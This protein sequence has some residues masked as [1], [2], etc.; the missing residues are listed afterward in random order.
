MTLNI[1]A[2]C[3][4]LT[5]ANSLDTAQG[6]A[7]AQ[8][9]TAQWVVVADSWRRLVH[10]CASLSRLV[11]RMAVALTCV[12]MERNVTAQAALA[13]AGPCEES[14]PAARTFDDVTEE[15]VA[16]G[17]RRMADAGDVAENTLRTYDSALRG[18]DAWLSERRPGQ[19][20]DDAALAEYLVVLKSRGRSAASAGQVVAAAK[21]RA[22]QQGEASPAGR[23]T[24]EM[25]RRYRRTPKA[26]R[27]Q[28]RGISWEEAD[29]M[30]DLAARSGG[31]RGLRD[32]ALVSMTSDA[33]LRV[34]EVASVRVEDVAFEDDGTARL[35]VRSGKTDQTGRG[36]VLFLGMP[37][38][39]RVREWM[40]VAGIR[41]GP[42]FRRLPR[43][44]AVS[45]FGI[46]AGSVRRVI[47]QRA[48]A[49]GIEGRV[50]GHSLRVGSAQSLAKRGAGLVEMQKAGR[51]ASPDMPA[52]YT[53]SQR[54]AEGAVAR[55]RYRHDAEAPKKGEKAKER[56]TARITRA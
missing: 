18:L 38:A 54:V 39:T 36:A 34:S 47:V 46:G 29:E 24:A 15:D 42:L 27:G 17:T 37:T 2:A 43:G 7:F 1:M 13:A 31:S 33:M 10:E 45:A 51:W 6:S 4:G 19:A 22:V 35:L 52:H 30:C 49:A 28:V 44:G 23:D 16:E 26:G 12:W 5:V 53:R 14:S 3:S 8:D 20:L 56:L 55:L 41:E 40:A 32:A 21:R 48:R 11:V 9:L 50:S 25:L